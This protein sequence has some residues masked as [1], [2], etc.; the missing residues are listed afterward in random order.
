MV[1]YVVRQ[2]VNENFYGILKC[3]EWLMA[4]I[5]TI[6]S[7]VYFDVLA[8]LATFYDKIACLIYKINI[9]HFRVTLITADHSTRLPHFFHFKLCSV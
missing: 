5:L 7:N 2:I 8:I 1:R 4:M 6:V 3:F 9:S